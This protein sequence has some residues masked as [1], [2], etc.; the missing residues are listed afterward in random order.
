VA[1]FGEREP[2][3]RAKALNLDLLGPVRFPGLRQPIANRAETRDRI[4]DGRRIAAARGA[5][6][7]AG[8]DGG[9]PEPVAET[10]RDIPGARVEVLR[11]RELAVDEVDAARTTVDDALRRA[12]S[13]S[14]ERDAALTARDVAIRERDEA[15]RKRDELR[16]RL[17]DAL[18]RPAVPAERPTAQPWTA[19]A[20]VLGALAIVVL[21]VAAAVI[22]VLI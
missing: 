5:D 16:S 14:L 19:R 17:N 10:V 15:R 4:S 7:C 21:W 13:A 9:V 1:A 11:A 20:V 22:R 6:A 12:Q 18:A 3:A 2:R 8:N